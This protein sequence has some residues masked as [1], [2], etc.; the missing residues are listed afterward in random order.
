MPYFHY[1]KEAL[2][3]TVYFYLVSFKAGTYNNKQNKQN[4]DQRKS[5]AVSVS[6]T[7]VLRHRYPPFSYQATSKFDIV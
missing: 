1:V 6:A 4:N 2:C 5:A 7:S 3:L